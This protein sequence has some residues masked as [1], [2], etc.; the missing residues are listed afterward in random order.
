MVALSEIASFYKPKLCIIQ[1]STHWAT[2]M[3]TVTIETYLL[4]SD[5]F[6]EAMDSDGGFFLLKPPVHFRLWD[7]S[8]KL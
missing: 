1:N 6:P 2:W 5:G 8:H 7:W 4:W 3:I